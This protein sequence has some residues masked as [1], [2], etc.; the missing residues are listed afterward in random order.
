MGT[1]RESV[2]KQFRA[3]VNDGWIALEKGKVVIV[4][5]DEIE[6]LADCVVI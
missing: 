1:T 3:W 5:R 2:N 4:E 6:K